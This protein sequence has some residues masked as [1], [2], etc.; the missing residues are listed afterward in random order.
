MLRSDGTAGKAFN[1][2][3]LVQTKMIIAHTMEYKGLALPLSEWNLRNYRAVDYPA[4]SVT[5]NDCFFEMRQALGLHPVNCCDERSALL[6]KADNIFIL[7]VDGV[8]VGSVAIYGNEI[9]DLIVVRGYQRKGYGQGL[10]RF[11]VARMQ[12]QGVTP[13]RL[14]VADWN[15][16]AMRLY[17]RNGFAVVGT[18]IVQT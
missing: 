6:E 15:Q 18:E 1:F 4:Y 11:A 3:K 12:R 8:L 9:D 14:H 5:Y 10:L 16:A 2:W 7:E 17:S 13:I